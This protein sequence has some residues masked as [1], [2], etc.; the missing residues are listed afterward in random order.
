M[1]NDKLKIKNKEEKDKPKQ[2]KLT[3]EILDKMT[4]LATTGLG[5]VAAL[6][7]ND[8]IKALFRKI[9]GEQET[10]WAMF[11]YA[12]L[13]TILVVI[14]TIQLSRL[15][16]IA[17]EREEELISVLDRKVRKKER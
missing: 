9:F 8:A 11:G 5:L 2:Q 4:N 15:L 7:W 6:A 10:L 12:A 13:V 16:K 3:V 1:K 17:K 14:L